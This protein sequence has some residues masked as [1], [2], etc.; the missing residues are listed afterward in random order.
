MRFVWF[1]VGVARVG[2]CVKRLWVDAIPAI[3]EMARLVESACSSILPKIS[4]WRHTS[5]LSLESLEIGDTSKAPIKRYR[6][7]LV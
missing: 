7:R 6:Q 5:P 4:S 3:F 1:K 2:T